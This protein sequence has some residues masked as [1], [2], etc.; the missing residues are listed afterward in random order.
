MADVS[1]A[2]NEPTSIL[3]RLNNWFDVC[4]AAEA[5]FYIGEYDG[6]IMNRNVLY[7]IF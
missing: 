4:W 7:F 6:V 5:R 1:F 2:Y 3:F